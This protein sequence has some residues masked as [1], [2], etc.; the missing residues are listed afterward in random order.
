MGASTT[1][2]GLCATGL[3]VLNAVQD[4]YCFFDI[5][6]PLRDEKPPNK[7][8]RKRRYYKPFSKKT[9]E[10]LLP[11]QVAII[12]ESEEEIGEEEGAIS[13]EEKSQE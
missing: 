8:T 2:I 3:T 9:L 12:E 7:Q 4:V 13:E 1:Q 5:R 6:V 11:G 10:I